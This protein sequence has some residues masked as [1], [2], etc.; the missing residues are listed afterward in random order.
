MSKGHGRV[1]QAVLAILRRRL[2][3]PYSALL[4]RSPYGCIATRLEAFPHYQQGAGGGGVVGT[5]LMSAL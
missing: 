5:H 4:A 2:A 1:Q 3:A